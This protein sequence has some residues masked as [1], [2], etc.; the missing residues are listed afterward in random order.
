MGSDRARKTYN[1]TRQYRGV[2]HQQ[3]RVVLEADLNESQEILS[4]EGRRLALDLI[5]ARGAPARGKPAL[6][7]EAKKAPPSSLVHPGKV[8]FDFVASLGD[9]RPGDLPGGHPTEPV[10]YSEQPSAPPLPASAPGPELVYLQ[11]VRDAD[12]AVFA[13]AWSVER[14][15]LGRLPGGPDAAMSLAARAFAARGQA[16]KPSPNKGALES[17]AR[18]QVRL[19]EAK[20][21][22]SLPISLRVQISKGG[23][24]FVWKTGRTL[25]GE[26]RPATEI[27]G[28]AEWTQEQAIRPDE[29]VTLLDATGAKTAIEIMLSG[30]AFVE[31]DY[32]VI[33]RHTFVEAPATLASKKQGLRPTGPRRSAYA[34][35]VVE[36]SRA[37]DLESNVSCLSAVEVPAGKAGDFTLG[38]GV[39]ETGGVRFEV[40][41]PITFS[42]PGRALGRELVY[43]ELEEREV[44]AVE[45]PVLREP[46]L[47]G[48][49]TAQRLRLVERLGCMPVSA[50]QGLDAAKQLYERTGQILEDD[51]RVSSQA[52]LLARYPASGASENP[53]CEPGQVKGY[54]GSENQLVRVQ[55]SPSDGKILWAWDGGSA[56]YRATYESGTTLLLQGDPVDVYHAP[57]K[58]QRAEILL[59]D[60]DLGLATSDAHAFMAAAVGFVARIDGYEERRLKLEGSVRDK[61]A[62][63]SKLVPPGACLYVRIWENEQPSSATVAPTFPLTDADGRT[64]GLTVALSQTNAVP[65]DHWLLALRPATP[66][67]V[68]PPR[69]LAEHQPPD[70]PRRWFCPIAVVSYTSEG[71][72]QVEEDC[73]PRFDDVV[74]LTARVDVAEAGVDALEAQADALGA[75]TAALEDRADKLEDRASALEGRATALEG[76][77]TALEGR[78]STLETT[79]A[80]LVNDVNA[81]KGAD[82]A[83]Q[84]QIDELSL[85]G[86]GCCTRV[87]GPA[88]VDEAGGLQ[89]VIDDLVSKAGG[90]RVTLCLMPGEYQMKKPIRLGRRHAGLTI[91]G[92]QGGAS[93]RGRGSGGFGGSD[94]M[95]AFRDGLVVLYHTENITLDDL[96]FHLPLV[97]WSALEW[98][99]AGIDR[100]A[101]DA[102]EQEWLRHLVT[103]IGVRPVRCGNLSI[104]NCTFRLALNQ[105]ERPGETYRHVFGAGVFAAGESWGLRIEG[106]SF[107]HD[108]RYLVERIGNPSWLFGYVHAPST[109]VG[110]GSHKLSKDAVV[111]GTVVHAVLDEAVLQSNLFAGLTAAVLSQASTGSVRIAHNRV[112]DC[113]AGFCLFG[114][115]VPASVGISVPPAFDI[116][117]QNAGA[118]PQAL[119]AA[120][121]EAMGMTAEAASSLVASAT[122]LVW[123]NLTQQALGTKIGPLK[124]AG[125]T[126]ELAISPP[127]PLPP[128]T[129]PAQL[130]N[131]FLTSVGP[132]V[133]EVKAV[134]LSLG[135]DAAKVDRLVSPA[136]T[137]IGPATVDQ[138]EA[139][140]RTFN[141]QQARFEL[142]PRHASAPVAVPS[143]SSWLYSR[144][145]AMGELA[146][147]AHAA[148]EQLGT[149]DDPRLQEGLTMARAYPL[150]P[151]LDEE[152]QKQHD[153]T[154]TSIVRPGQWTRFAREAGSARSIGST[155]KDAAFAWYEFPYD[156][157]WT[158]FG[159][160]VPWEAPAVDFLTHLHRAL[161]SVELGFASARPEVRHSL[162]LQVS[163][164]DVE[165]TLPAN[166]S[167]PA[168]RVIGDPRDRASTVVVSSN[169]SCSSAL[170]PTVSIVMAARSTLTGNVLVNQFVYGDMD[171]DAKAVCLLVIPGPAPFATAI[172]GNVLDGSSALPPRE[173]PAPLDSWLALNTGGEGAP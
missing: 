40:R 32:W 27:I 28:R 7:T 104:R 94:P 61:L 121:V 149:T 133:A 56:L 158:L 143:I 68:D 51:G 110:L 44:G 26:K 74:T 65:G 33:E 73:L 31:G 12:L 123:E 169:R 57:K 119:S 50:G 47:G 163:D 59:P 138:A 55:A 13:L 102:A 146:R 103:S 37:G 70:G 83:L 5:G 75:R 23:E 16:F 72:L 151:P 89:A 164:N 107:L 42:Q 134:L 19:R 144:D 34:L 82:A 93:L 136:D 162:R 145:A 11:L 115:E 9:A 165:A 95:G 90:R 88:Q 128:S 85:A 129:P 52:R 45:D 172:T 92:C 126:V 10:V 125:A 141:Q 22:A 156:R 120:L 171:P 116:L 108:T 48:P 105:D 101:L 43:L 77:A 8:P 147:R 168:L 38:R 113:H 140:E 25:P 142:V 78:A 98:D 148:M 29:W 118:H 35:A 112:R 106:C 154:C 1:E 114:S 173:L 152:E 2:V 54:L 81:L 122:K 109:T 17:T 24:S 127:P 153:K 96:H 67:E 6:W 117:L 157:W 97:K 71:V 66:A 87:V 58:D 135:L 46:A 111:N 167:G 170:G 131:V 155:V 80:T 69:Y 63:H 15:A 99:L 124:N 76:R 21:G 161:Y 53:A 160:P 130:Y 3:G 79:T 150:P 86:G 41:E 14:I 64:I 100:S 30:R 4:E 159:S 139:L 84:Q 39:I 91:E 62:E 20:P 60:V 166:S 132:K 18:L 137:R 49:D 36:W